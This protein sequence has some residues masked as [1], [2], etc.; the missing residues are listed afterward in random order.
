MPISSPLNA[1]T[2]LTLPIVSF[3]CEEHS[4]LTSCY[5]FIVNWESLDQ[6]GITAKRGIRK[7]IAI[8]VTFQEYMKR[9]M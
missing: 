6:M 7:T 2:V 9:M 4:A 3:A 1:F 5:A 8:K